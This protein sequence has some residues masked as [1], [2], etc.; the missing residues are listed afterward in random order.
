MGEDATN[1]NAVL[2]G[3]AFAL[4]GSID[5]YRAAQRIAERIVDDVMEELNWRNLASFT[6]DEIKECLI[7]VFEK[8]L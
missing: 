3:V 2:A 5:D 8:K 7:T 6:Q 1:R 4:T